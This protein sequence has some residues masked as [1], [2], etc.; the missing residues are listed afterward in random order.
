[1]YKALETK[2]R[3]LRYLFVKITQCCNLARQGRAAPGADGRGVA[4]LL[5]LPADEV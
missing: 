3:I 4:A 1:M 2:A 5:R